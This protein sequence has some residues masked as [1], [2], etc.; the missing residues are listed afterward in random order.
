MAGSISI[1]GAMRSNLLALQNTSRL[2]D[3]TQERLA[4][5]KKVNS[6]LDNPSSFFT[7]QGLS[8]R[9]TDLSNRLDGIG[10][11]LSTLQATQQAISSI[12]TLVQQAQAL[13]QSATDNFSTSATVSTNATSFNTV[14]S[15]INLA[16]SDASYKGV[17]LL[18][19]TPD[20]LTA[21]FNENGSS[22]LA[23]SGVAST[24]TAL[25][26]SVSQ[27]TSGANATGLVN[28]WNSQTGLA[29]TLSLMTNAMTT[30]RATAAS[31]GT[32]SA[33]IQTRQDFATD[34]INTL[35]SGADNL[36]LANM[37]EEAANM[38]ALQTQRQMGTNSLS[39]A[40]QAAQSVLQMFR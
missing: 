3:Q 6:A 24:F 13:V 40:S 31:F 4:T 33:I 26:L 12:T 8:N 16:V 15:Q 5:G 1:S 38:L 17:N 11:A 29:L 35:K 34:M 10:Q 30:L 39:M 22:S 37:N 28:E 18:K 25:S 21:V 32:S 9:A 14:M 27:F 36:T 19:A 2:Q 23:V 20:T 7:A